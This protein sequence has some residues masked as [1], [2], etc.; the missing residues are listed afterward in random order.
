MAGRARAGGSEQALNLYG[1]ELLPG[2]FVSGSGN[3]DTWLD[4]ERE[5][6]RRRAS[7]EAWSLAQGAEK[8]G[9]VVGASHWAR[10][11]VELSPFDE[12]ALCRLLELLDR[13][14]D[15]AGAIQ[16]YDHFA[17]RLKGEYETE[18]AP[19]TVALITQIR[20]RSASPE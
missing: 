12:A 9:N 17:R 3:F 13:A 11:A 6:L 4:G 20:S 19:E 2:F 7:E 18:P 14:G 1:G 10:R 8:D 5:R 16:L 15:R